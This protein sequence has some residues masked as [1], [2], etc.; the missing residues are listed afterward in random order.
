[1]KSALCTETD[2]LNTEDAYKH[3]QCIWRLAGTWHSAGNGNRQ[4]QCER[5]MNCFVVLC[6]I[7]LTCFNVLLAAQNCPFGDNK[8]S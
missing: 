8:E 7:S 3:R 1:M 4:Q 2:H 5:V 6:G